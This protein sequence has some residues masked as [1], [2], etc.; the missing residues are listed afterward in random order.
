MVKVETLFSYRYIYVEMKKKKRRN[1]KNDDYCTPE[2]SYF[3][4]V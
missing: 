4:N 1:Y 2:F 3:M